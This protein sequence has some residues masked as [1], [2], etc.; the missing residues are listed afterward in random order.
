VS[1]AAYAG[2]ERTLE[3]SRPN[4]RI[5]TDSATGKVL[6]FLGQVVQRNFYGNGE[7]EILAVDKLTWTGTIVSPTSTTSTFWTFTDHQNS[8]RDIVSGTLPTLGQVV[9]H[10]QYDSFGRL[11]RQTTGPQAGAATTPGVGIDFGYAGRPLEARTG[12]SDNRARW[13]EPGTGKFINEDPSGFKGGDTNL[14]RYV[15]NDPLNQVDPSGL[16]GKYVQSNRLWIKC[17]IA[18]CDARRPW[19]TSAFPPGDRVD[20]FSSEVHGGLFSRAAKKPHQGWLRGLSGDL[21]ISP[22]PPARTGRLRSRAAGTA[23]C[24]PV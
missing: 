20:C 7:D 14:F 15:G 17:R 4:D 8:V 19:K 21:R 24:S 10:R 5:V 18:G 12:L 11:V 22:E 2:G 16:T 13:Y 6:G 9:E 3:I 1:F 23:R